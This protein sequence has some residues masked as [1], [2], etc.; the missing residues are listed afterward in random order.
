MRLRALAI[1]SALLAVICSASAALTLAD[2]RPPPDCGSTAPAATFGAGVA[3]SP[4]TPGR[5]LMRLGGRFSCPAGAEWWFEYGTTPDYGERTASNDAAVPV[6]TSS[7]TATVRTDVDGLEYGQTYHYRLV[8]RYP[9]GEIQTGGD[10]VVTVR[11]GALRPPQRVSFSW[12]TRPTPER[13]TLDEVKVLDAPA[14]A[15]VTV[16]C[17][18]PGS[19]LCKP[20][21]RK[22]V[23]G[24]RP[25]VFKD[26]SIRPPAYVSVVVGGQGVPTEARI[27]PRP[28]GG[29]RLETFCG[30]FP[31]ALNTRCLS[32]A[33]RSRGPRLQGLS[34]SDVVRGTHVD[35]ACRG[36]GCPS[37]D[38]SLSTGKPA[39]G[40]YRDLVLRRYDR[41]QPGAELSVFVTRAPTYGVTRTFRVTPEKVVGG[42]YRCLAPTG[43]RLVVRCP[44][45][46][47]V[48]IG[49]G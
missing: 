31:V 34:I 37:R 29:P 18:G 35:V 33:L 42:S 39:N 6:V 22:I 23:I 26:W 45:E 30:G 46:V 11:P 7:D 27:H 10:T 4:S 13:T 14:G 40:L 1:V 19:S 9:D 44:R 41:L 36:P 38:L 8:V 12:S 43:P 3:D 49:R 48:T 24:R 15:K 16:S 28:R 5:V 21:E 2:T 17:V 32:V 20:F 25:T 47:P